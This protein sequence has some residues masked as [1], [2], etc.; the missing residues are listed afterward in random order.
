MRFFTILYIFIVSSL[1]QAQSDM[2]SGINM[3]VQNAKKG[4]YWAL[5][6]I[7]EKKSKLDNDLIAEDKLFASVKLS[8]EINGFKIES[9]GLNNSY[10]V[11]IKLFRSEESLIK[12]GYIKEKEKSETSEENK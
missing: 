5:N 10:I 4:I 2:D 11:T 12:D 9:T 6:N 1:I 3:A 8:K 7:P